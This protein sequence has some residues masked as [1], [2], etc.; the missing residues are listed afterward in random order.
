MRHPQW[1]VNAIRDKEA[2]LHQATGGE[3]AV[4]GETALNIDVS[5][6]IGGALLPYLGII[7]GL[8]VLLLMLVCRS[9]LVPLKA[10]RG[11]LPFGPG[12]GLVPAY[13]GH[14]P[15]GEVA[16]VGGNVRGLAVVTGW[17]STR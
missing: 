17:W 3:I 1:T 2:A 5:D 11:G 16:E 6:K 9:V 12:G 13:L 10:T 14:D 7:V 8:A 15:A 4:T